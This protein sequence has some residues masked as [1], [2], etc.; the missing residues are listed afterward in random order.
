MTSLIKALQVV[1]FPLWLA[2]FLAILG[3]HWLRA[4]LRPNPARRAMRPLVDRL[5]LA[6]PRFLAKDGR[7]GAAL[8]GPY[9]WYRLYLVVDRT[10]DLV[11]TVRSVVR[12]A[13]Y[14][15]DVG[16]QLPLKV[17]D[18]GA[19]SNRFVASNRDG[20]VV[21][22]M[23][24]DVQPTV[25]GRGRHVVFGH[26]ATPPAGKAILSLTLVLPPRVRLGHVTAPWRDVA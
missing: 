21:V 24:W 22:G 15:L 19:V 1:L 16:R 23:S 13:G 8:T 17:S 11:A 7:T 10:P 25:Y 6:R 20:T 12:H 9:P 5:E 18:T 3:F 14:R 2:A 4:R 26:L